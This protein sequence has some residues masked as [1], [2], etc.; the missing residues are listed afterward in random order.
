VA[1][2]SGSAVKSPTVVFDGAARQR[3]DPRHLCACQIIL[4]LA[5]A[6][7]QHSSSPLMRRLR[8]LKKAR[9]IR[10]RHGLFGQSFEDVAAMSISSSPHAMAW[11]RSTM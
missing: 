5:F 8:A 10:T 4:D 7:A 1:V 2:E 9:E 6:A 3:N 11:P